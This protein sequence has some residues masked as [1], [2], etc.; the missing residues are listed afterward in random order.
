MPPDQTGFLEETVS[1]GVLVLWGKESIPSEFAWKAECLGEKLQPGEE[2][3]PEG[4]GL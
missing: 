2:T 1:K 3:I 4:L